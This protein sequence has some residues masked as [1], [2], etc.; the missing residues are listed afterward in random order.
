MQGEVARLG[1]EWTKTIAPIFGV[2]Q[3]TDNALET[4]LSSQAKRT[5]STIAEAQT[6]GLSAD[7]HEKLKVTLQAESIAKEKGITITDALRASITATALAAAAAQQTLQGAQLTQEMLAPWDLRNQKLQL[8]NTMLQEGSIK[9]DAFSMAQQRIQ[10]P[11]F[12]AASI[13]AIDIAMQIDGLATSAVN[14]LSSNLAA[15]ATG[16]KSAAEAFEAFATSIIADIA[17]MIV[18]LVIYKAPPRMAIFGFADGGAVGGT[19][20]SLSGTGGLFAS[21]GNVSGPG[22]GTSDSIPAMLSNGEFVV[23]AQATKQFAPLLNAINSGNLP[24]F[25]DGGNVGSSLNS[26]AP[27]S[28]TAIE[29]RGINPSTFYTGDNI[30]SLIEGVNR[31]IGDGYRLNVSPA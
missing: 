25:A 17:A 28:P 22:T 3:A 19:G 13:A 12:T 5:A 6:V 18:K 27:R 9:S 2:K 21:G 31:A 26:A 11:A 14:S 16:T 23:N 24:A 1:A 10:F 20:L 15:L 30:R 4:F 7:A 29:V 8:Y